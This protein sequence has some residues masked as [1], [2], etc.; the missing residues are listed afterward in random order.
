M[1]FA[2]YFALNDNYA[3]SKMSIPEFVNAVRQAANN[4]LFAG[5]FDSATLAQIESLAMFTDQAAIQKQLS[6]GEL[7]AAF[8]IDKAMIEQLFIL[9]FGGEEAEGKTMTLNQF[10]GFLADNILTN[11]AYAGF[12]TAEQKQQILALNSIAGVAASK[13]RRFQQRNLPPV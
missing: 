13:K 11:E 7:A 1:M 5:N 12:F 8:G 4:P 3:P 6:A 10:T 9:R 2:Y